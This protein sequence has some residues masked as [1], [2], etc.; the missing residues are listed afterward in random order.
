M[1]K[2]RHIALIAAVARNGVIGRD[3]RLPWHLPADLRHFRQLTLGKPVLMGRRTFESLGKPLPGR[4]NIVLTRD[5]DFRAPGCIVVHA[6]T[7][8]IAAAGECEELMVMGGAALY[9]AALPLA[10]RMYLTRIHHA[11]AGD[12][13]F[14]A[15]DEREWVTTAREDHAPDGDNPYPYSFITLQRRSTPPGD[16]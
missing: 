13:R 14:V 16:G 10:D 2:A 8:G 7:E 5:P 4:T 12:T 11:F 1:G 6:L 9:A 3:N 15:Y